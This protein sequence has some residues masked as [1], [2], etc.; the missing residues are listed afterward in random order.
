MKSIL[1]FFSLCFACVGILGSFCSNLYHGDYVF[2]VGVAIA[3]VFAWPS[4]KS[5]A[6][7]IMS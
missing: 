1:L 6:K 3:A 4:F 7:K 5:T 2:A